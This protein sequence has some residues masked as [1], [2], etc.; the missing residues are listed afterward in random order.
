MLKE[1]CDNDQKKIHQWR[2][3]PEVRDVMFSHHE[4]TLDDHLEW[5][6]KVK[7]DKAKQ[8]LLFCNEDEELGVVYIFDIDRKNKTCH[9]GFYFGAL[10]NVEEKRKFFLWQALEV[11]AIEYVFREIAVEKLI[12]ESFEFNKAVLMVHLRNGFKKTDEYHKNR[13][14]KSIRVIETTS[15]APSS[16]D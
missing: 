3:L 9:W 16:L 8:L 11:E 13:Q 2:N 6:D 7:L 10:E 4:I 15:L 1:A 12:C 14:G 5:W